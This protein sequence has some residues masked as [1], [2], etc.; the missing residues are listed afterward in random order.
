MIFGGLFAMLSFSNYSEF[1]S[2]KFLREM[3]DARMMD[4]AEGKLAAERGTTKEIRDYGNLMV[5]DQAMLLAEIK[6][7]AAAKSVKLPASIS[8]EKSKALKNLAE[9]QGKDFD[10]KFLNMIKIDHKRDVKEFKEA[11][12]SDNARVVIF[13]KKFLPTI[14]SHLEGVEKIKE[15]M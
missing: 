12:D 11:I 13:A 4:A 1:D 3:A 8:E 5:K 15:E 6:K 9:K 2:V 7:V 10:R 14:Q